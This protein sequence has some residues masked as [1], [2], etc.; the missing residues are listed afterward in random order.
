MRARSAPNASRSSSRSWPTCSL[1]FERALALADDGDARQ[2]LL[3]RRA[4][5]QLELFD[6]REAA[7]TFAELLVAA[8]S[9]GDRVRELEVLLGLGRAYY[10]RALDDQSGDYVD[11]WRAT[12]ER[13]YALAKELGDKRGQARALLPTVW[14]TDAWPAYRPQA[15]WNA[16][17]TTG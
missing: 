3:A 16:G 12:Y 9:R 7:E 1:F 14:F 5:C 6:G 11:R 17:T 13:A 8:E 10:L 4:R 15:E 2:S